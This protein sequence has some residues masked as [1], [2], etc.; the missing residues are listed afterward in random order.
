L[1]NGRIVLDF[2]IVAVGVLLGS[3]VGFGTVFAVF[4]L[5]PMIE[6]FLL[7]S[8]KLSEKMPNLGR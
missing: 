8:K 1:K 2:V 3:S 6:W 5:G 7:Q 4:L